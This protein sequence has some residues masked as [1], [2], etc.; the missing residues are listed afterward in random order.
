MVEE[1]EFLACKFLGIVESQIEKGKKKKIFRR[2]L[3]QWDNFKKLIFVK[4][5]SQVI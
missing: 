5:T 1:S 3:L 2:Y 4:K